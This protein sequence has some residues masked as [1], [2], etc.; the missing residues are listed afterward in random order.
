MRSIDAQLEHILALGGI[1]AAGPAV[2][3]AIEQ[4]IA[5]RKVTNPAAAG[6]VH[7]AASVAVTRADFFG[8]AELCSP[9]LFEARITNQLRGVSADAKLKQR[10]AVQPPD[11]SS[12]EEEEGEG[13][14]DTSAEFRKANAQLA[15]AVAALAAVVTKL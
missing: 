2:S 8:A 4:V 1:L 11:E 13:E 15:K 3:D 5:R 10:R 6:L 7:L 9:A 14:G 12:D